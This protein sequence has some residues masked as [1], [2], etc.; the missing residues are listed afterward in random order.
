MLH[1]I[2]TQKT[3]TWNSNVHHHHHKIPLLD[4]VLSR[5]I[6]G[7]LLIVWFFKICLKANHEEPMWKTGQ[8]KDDKEEQAG[9][10]E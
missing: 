9:Q 7:R 10:M 4:L 8:K 2:T 1:S 3:S 5:V 6:A